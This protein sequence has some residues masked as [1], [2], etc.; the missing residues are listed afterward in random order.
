MEMTSIATTI[1]M[2]R[3]ISAIWP[4]STLFSRLTV[5]DRRAS[6]SR[7]RAARQACTLPEMV[8]FWER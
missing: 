4:K 6:N 7:V 1:T 3:M 2:E 5:A 8:S